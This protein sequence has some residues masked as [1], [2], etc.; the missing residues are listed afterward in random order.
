M[1]FKFTQG[2]HIG[3]KRPF[4]IASDFP[5]NCAGNARKC[6]ELYIPGFMSTK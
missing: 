3:S 6:L 5:C 4:Q 1:Q 2:P